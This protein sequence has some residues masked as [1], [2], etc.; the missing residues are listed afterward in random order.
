MIEALLNEIASNG[1]QGAVVPA[2]R[3][4]DLK[5]EMEDL[6]SGENHAFS[7]WMAG[8]MAI[9]SDPGFEAQSIIVV[10]TPSP[11][12]M[13]HFNHLG[14]PAHCIVP[15]YYTDESTIGI[16]VLEY[17]NACLTLF[18]FT[19]K[20]AG[21]L[22]QKL[23]AVRTG[24]NLYGRNNVSFSEKLGS[25]MRILTYVSDLPGKDTP[26]YPSRRMNACDT[27]L[28]CVTACP[29]K[30]INPDHRIIDAYS[31]L[32]LKNELPGDF[33]DWLSADSHNSLV[34]CMKCQDCCPG[35]A[36]VKNNITQGVT[37]TQDETAELLSHTNDES[38]SEAL[39]AKLEAAGLSTEYWPV[40]PRNL[41]ALLQ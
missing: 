25:Y 10:V 15:P 18:G 29:T 14:K 5:R 24:L 13:L 36:H 27:C 20:E 2:S 39:A 28:A 1:D 32:T 16:K 4:E 26:W 8:T 35:N 6:K 34:G 9:P 31:C 33:P 3:F 30:A 40:L 12:V 23:L 22:P 21:Q 11:K 37:F 38:F 7:D 17:I 41:A 19:A